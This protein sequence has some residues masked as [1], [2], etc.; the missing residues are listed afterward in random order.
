MFQIEQGK[1][2]TQI[3]GLVG[4]VQQPI[5]DAYPDFQMGFS[6]DVEWKRFRFGMHWD[7]KKGGDVI[8]LTRLLFDAGA[9]Q[10][11]RRRW[12]RVA[13]G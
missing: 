11:R 7:W 9:E 13:G 5:G 3:I 10:P 1:S 2:A 12:R 8:N 6:N 4:G